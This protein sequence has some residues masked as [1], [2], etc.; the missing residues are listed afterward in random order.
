MAQAAASPQSGAELKA[1]QADFDKAIEELA[2]VSAKAEQE[3]ERTAVEMAKHMERHEEL[4]RACQVRIST[5]HTHTNTRTHK[6]THT[7]QNTHAHTHTHIR[8][9]DA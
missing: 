5:G 3:Q 1:V 2:L 6:H 9:R 4:S 7:Q 8:A